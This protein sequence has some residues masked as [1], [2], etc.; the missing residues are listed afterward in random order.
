MPEEVRQALRM[1][2]L[3]LGITQ[4]HMAKCLGFKR[5]Q[6]YSDIERGKRGV[7]IGLALAIAEILG[8]SADELFFAEK[9]PIYR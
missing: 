6:T 4:I 7:Q 8:T 3:S 5:P 9:Y 1:K 2:R